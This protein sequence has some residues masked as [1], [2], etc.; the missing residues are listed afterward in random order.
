MP[1]IRL[2]ALSVLV[3]GGLFF[4]RPADAAQSYD[5]C[6]N[7]ITS[8]PATINTQGVWCLNKDLATN[9]A[10]GNAITVNANNVTVDCNDFKIGGLAAGP[11]STATGIAD[12]NRQ[13]TTIRNCNIRGF[14]YGI[15]LAGGNGGGRL[16]ENNRLDNNLYTGIYIYGDNNTVRRNRVY[17]T[18]GAT[19]RANIYAI[20]VM[21]EVIE[22]TVSG[23]FADKSGGTLH[24]INLGGRDSVARGNK[25][26]GFDMDARQGG[27]VANAY[28]VDLRHY[29]QRAIANDIGAY[30]PG[31]S[32]NVSGTGIDAPS[33]TSGL[34]FC[35]DNTVAGFTTNIGSSCISGGNLTPP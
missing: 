8:L 26:S 32:G 4:A 20:D 30:R 14:S 28:G 13:N 11:G 1:L 29:R 10:S 23:L 21:A 12:E 24:G 15:R 34:A 9:I 27:S 18:G 25:V 7:F 33:Q 6:N 2:A 35:R 31:L 3:T 19:G 17:D 5:S 16:V 22:N